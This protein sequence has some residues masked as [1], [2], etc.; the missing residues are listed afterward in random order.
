MPGGLSWAELTAAVSSALRDGGCRGW[1]IG[2][3]NTDLDPG[4]HAAHQIL[5]FL[6]GVIGT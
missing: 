5:N 4:R 6:A 2:V 3:Y 1:S